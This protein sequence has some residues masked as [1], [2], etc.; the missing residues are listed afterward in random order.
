MYLELQLIIIKTVSLNVK[1]QGDREE[2]RGKKLK[3]IHLP[4]RKAPQI[5]KKS[6]TRNN[7]INKI[8]LKVCKYNQQGTTLDTLPF[9]LNLKTY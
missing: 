7:S 2:G 9:T 6:K 3:T 8:L 1:E 4:R 5:A